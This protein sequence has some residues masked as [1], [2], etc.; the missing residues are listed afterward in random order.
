[1]DGGIRA[2]AERKRKD[3]NDRECRMPDQL[4]QAVAN[5]GQHN[6]LKSF[7]SARSAIIGST[8]IA[9]RAGS[10][11]ATNA[12]TETNSTIPA[13]VPGS[14]AP[15]PKRRLLNNRVAAKAPA[16]P[17]TRLMPTSVMACPTTRRKIELLPAP[18]ASRIPIS[19]VRSA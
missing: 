13:K 14:D 2:D 3:G 11:A 8:R 16:R 10:H 1:E 9:R 15:T 4:A 18:S 5:V 7:H 12:T 6:D 19:P 17:S